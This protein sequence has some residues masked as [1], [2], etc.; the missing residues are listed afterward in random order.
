MKQS[1]NFL[2]YLR[3]KP[4][5]LTVIK[6]VFHFLNY[7][8]QSNCDHVHYTVQPYAIFFQQAHA[9]LIPFIISV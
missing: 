7:V 4:Q 8:K 9:W 5:H 6:S 2:A 1:K 3:N